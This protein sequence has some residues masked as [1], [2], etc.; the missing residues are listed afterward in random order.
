MSVSCP[1]ACSRASTR[2][3]ASGDSGPCGPSMRTPALPAASALSGAIVGKELQAASMANGQ[4]LA[5]RD[6]SERTGGIEDL[7]VSARM[8]K[9]GLA[10]RVPSSGGATYNALHAG[11]P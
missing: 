4:A 6:N 9:G 1:A 2:F 11:Q 10:T 7:L 3:W 5:G 8:A